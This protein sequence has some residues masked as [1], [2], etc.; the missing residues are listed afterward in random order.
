MLVQTAP[1]ATNM[2]WGDSEIRIRGMLETS[3]KFNVNV[4]AGTHCIWDWGW[5]ARKKS[6]RL[7]LWCGV[8]LCT[9]NVMNS[10]WKAS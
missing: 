9:I 1:E 10:A 5:S 2:S 4:Y 7:E 3:A 8:R 6:A